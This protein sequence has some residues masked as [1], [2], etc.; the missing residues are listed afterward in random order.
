MTLYGQRQDQLPRSWIKENAKLPYLYKQI[1]V[2]VD[3]DELTP[4]AKRELFA[5]TRERATETSPLPSPAAS[6]APG[7]VGSDDAGKR[8]A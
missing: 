4:I 6:R 3:A 1:I 5:S 7:S 2:Q 8:T